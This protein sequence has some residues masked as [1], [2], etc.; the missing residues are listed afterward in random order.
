MTTGS[1]ENECLDDSQEFSY[2]QYIFRAYFTTFTYLFGIIANTIN[3]I[4]FSQKTMRNQPVNWFFFALSLSDLAVL[5]SSFF[6]YSMPVYVERAPE[7]S[8]LSVSLM[9]WFYPTSQIG[10]TM[11]VYLTVLVSV[12][13][14]LGV[15]HPFLIRRISNSS[16]VKIV[17]AT[18]VLFAF[19]F[20][21]TRWFEIRSD[22]ICEGRVVIAVPTVLMVNNSYIIIYRNCLYSLVMFFL[23]FSVLSFV[24]FKIIGT[25]RTSYKMRR[26]MTIHSLKEKKRGLQK[27]IS[28][29][30]QTTVSQNGSNGPETK[31]LKFPRLSQSNC[32]VAQISGSNCWNNI[33]RKDHGVTVMLVAITTEFLVFNLLAFAMNMIELIAGQAAPQ[34]SIFIFLLEISTLLVNING[35]STIVIYLIFGSKYRAVFCKLFHTYLKVPKVNLRKPSIYTA[36]GHIGDTTQLMNEKNGELKSQHSIKSYRD[37][38]SRRMTADRVE[39]MPIL[40]DCS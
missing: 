30:I 14:Y 9:V 36:S 5:I 8:R 33:D 13:R 19:L 27:K 18:A 3:I 23:P 12:H 1:N 16:A 21:T 26:Q 37:H 7:W 28:S 17:I 4:V 15:C 40:N 10:L 34:S 29:P 35:A 2:T 11:S 20:N 31:T 32:Q 22:E 6:V 39:R 24:N 25:L 38:N